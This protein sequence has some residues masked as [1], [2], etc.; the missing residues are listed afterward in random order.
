[1]KIIGINGSPRKDWNTAT[2]L[3]HA[4]DGAASKGAETELIHLYD[5]DYKGCISCFS[6]KRKGGK[7]Y[8][9]CAVNDGLKPVLQKIEE[10]DGIILGS[11]IYLVEVTGE[12][13]SF[14][15]RLIF[16]YL[17]YDENRTMLLSKKI[18]CGLIYTMNVPEE[19]LDLPGYRPMFENIESFISRAFS[20]V[21]SLYVTDT[22]QFDD[23]SKYEASRFNAEEKARRRKEVFPLDC[24]K[25]F[26]MGE[27]IASPDRKKG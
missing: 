16:Q 15:E 18:S 9:K 27:A 3:K 12:M 26:E 19:Y 11:P 10:A 20:P 5:L 23:Y 6:C 4:L 21:Q 22:Y 14:L 17:V 2:L 8:G 1:M 25:A 13:R 24:G 7:S